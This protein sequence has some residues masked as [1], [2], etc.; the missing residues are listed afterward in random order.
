MGL[1]HVEVRYSATQKGLLV[2]PKSTKKIMPQQSGTSST[3]QTLA[4]SC[5]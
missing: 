3:L 1:E 4:E 2:T 5:S